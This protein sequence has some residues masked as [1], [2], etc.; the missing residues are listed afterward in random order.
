MYTFAD[1]I[2]LHEILDTIQDQPGTIQWPKPPSPGQK[3][4]ANFNAGN[5]GYTMSFE[6]FDASMYFNGGQA[7]GYMISFDAIRNSSGE[8]VPLQQ[9]NAGRENPIIGQVQPPSK[10]GQY[11]VSP[12]GGSYKRVN[13]GPANSTG[14][15]QRVLGAMK[16]FV[17]KVQPE[18]LGWTPADPQLH[19]MYRMLIKKHA[20][21]RYTPVGG[22][23]TL[24]R[25]DL[26]KNLKPNYQQ[27]IMKH[28]EKD[29]LDDPRSYE[30]F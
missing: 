14:T 27:Q 13:A 18:V 11:T 2:K 22:Q 4:L 10:K 9:Q 17:T 24:V 20:V 5:V 6:P 3:A 16:E 15:F 25:D 1:Y 26:L 23:D 29:M 28:G 19:R 12:T 30:L 8:P 21:G 7:Y